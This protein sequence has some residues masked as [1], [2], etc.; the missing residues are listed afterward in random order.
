M[1]I[2]ARKRR[3]VLSSVFGGLS[4]PAIKPIALRMVYQVAAAIDIPVIG[5]GGISTGLDAVE[6]LMVGATAVQVGTAT[7]FNPLA[8][9]EVLEGIEGF[10]A[11]EGVDDARELIGAARVARSDTRRP[12]VVGS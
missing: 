10:L 9:I 5:C 1:A 8:P 4:G 7:F 2:D 11:E 6:F 3:P 12:T